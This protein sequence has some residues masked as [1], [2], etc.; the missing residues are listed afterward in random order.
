MPAQGGPGASSNNR[1][2]RRPTASRGG[3]RVFRRW[4][5]VW[6]AMAHPDGA[7]RHLPRAS[8]SRQPARFRCGS[9]PHP[10]T[11]H[12]GQRHRL[13]HGERDSAAASAVWRPQRSRG[14]GALGSSGSARGLGLGRVGGVLSGIP[15]SAAVGAVV[16]GARRVRGTQH[17]AGRRGLRRTGARRLR[18][19]R[20]VRPARRAADAGARVSPRRGTRPWSRDGG[21]ADPRSCGNDATAPIPRSWGGRFS[22]MDGHAR[23]S[24]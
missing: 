4:H 15:R 23:W 21:D 9:D 6:C 20:P 2:T 11:R 8:K 10:G 17:H 16:R 13:Q 18:H 3:G 24:A 5:A 19:A 7:P 14:D 22:S 1:V 12:R